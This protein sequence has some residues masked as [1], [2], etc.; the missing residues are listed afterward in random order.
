ML[1]I[2]NYTFMVVKKTTQEPV[3]LEKQTT[4]KEN[5]E[6]LIENNTTKLNIILSILLFILFIL[7][8]FVLI[9]PTYGFFRF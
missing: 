3:R 1:T 6:Q 4:N 5:L 8:C 2:G 7:L 9:P